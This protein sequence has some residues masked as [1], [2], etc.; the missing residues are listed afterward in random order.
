MS[1]L[2]TEKDALLAAFSY[3]LSR[4]EDKGKLADAVAGELVKTVVQS[5]YAAV[6]PRVDELPEKVLDILAADLKIQ[7]YEVDAPIL[8]K[9]QAIRECV[10]VHKYKGTK[11][12]VETALK[13]V[14]ENAKV[15]EWNQYNG[16]P[17]HFKIYIW[18]SGSDEEK[19]KRVFAKINYYKNARSVLEETVFILDI[20]AELPV[21]ASFCV[22]GKRRSLGCRLD[23]RGMDVLMAYPA[24]EAV[25]RIVGKRR[26]CGCRLD[27]RGMAELRAYPA[28]GT[29]FTLV[30]KRKS[31]YT[32]VHNGNME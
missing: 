5:E 20:K 22:A 26:A 24:G 3:S 2:I 15:I 17:F 21:K 11:Y 12:A 10:L 18:D 7:W 19:R 1:K 6:F 28:A 27:T 32:E 9:R 16:L 13:S 29:A 23:T 31:I 25:F 14:Y 8:N 4:D 30:G